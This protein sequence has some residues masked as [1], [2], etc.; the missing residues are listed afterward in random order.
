MLEMGVD[1]IEAPRHENFGKV[2]VFKDVYGN[3]WDFIEWV[4]S[5]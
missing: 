1:F 2:V 3:K 5:T 4:S